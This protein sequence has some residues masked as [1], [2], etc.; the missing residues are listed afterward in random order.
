M[1]RISNTEYEEEDID[2]DSLLE[3]SCSQNED[4]M[5][6]IDSILR[7][8]SDSQQ[9]LE[10]DLDLRDKEIRE[11]IATQEENR[12]KS[13][14]ELVKVKHKVTAA[15]IKRKPPG[16]DVFQLQSQH[17]LK[18][19]WGD[20][21]LERDFGWAGRRRLELSGMDIP[22]VDRLVSGQDKFMMVRYLAPETGQNNMIINKEEFQ[23]MADYLF[24]LSTVAEDQL[25]FSVLS[26]SL[27]DLLK[28]YG[29]SWCV[30]PT[31]LMTVLVNLGARQELLSCE[32][33]YQMNFRT[34]VPSL[35]RFFQ[36]R[37]DTFVRRGTVKQLGKKIKLTMLKNSIQLIGNLLRL[38]HRSDSGQSSTSILS[39]VHMVVIC[40]LDIEVV[41]NPSVTRPISLLIESLLLLL[42][43]YSEAV[44]QDLAEMLSANFFP[45]QMCPSSTSTW[46]YDTLPPY[47]ASSGYNHPHNMLAISNLLPPLHPIRHLVSYLYIQLIL[48]IT[49]VDLP[50]LVSTA[51]LVEMLD[52]HKKKWL[53]LA[54]DH[55]YC[56][57]V[58]LGLIDLMVEGEVTELSVKSPQ[59]SALK[60]L[61]SLVEQY[62]SKLDRNDPLDL[63]PVKVGELAAELISRWHLA[64]NAAENIH[65]MKINTGLLK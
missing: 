11:E 29:Y 36:A 59:H 35:P 13:E 45:H 61:V 48:G 56:L 20:L 55:H 17:S 27:L 15:L 24:Y 51:D 37:L 33:F 4:S 47:M 23:N 30:T 62:L 40:G 42:S 12:V 58:V 57:W 6:D 8:L 14:Q 7:P 26:K 32:A 49:S 34:S 1:N 52:T 25:S 18:F 38:P 43:S 28:S 10:A 3:N 9:A 19:L 44:R 64:V 39:M 41:D 63:D 22:L 50:G 53:S 54:K 2:L 60:K 65:S 16:L 31:H 5:L 21:S 46:S